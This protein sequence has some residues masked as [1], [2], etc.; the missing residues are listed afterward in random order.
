VKV[1]ITNS[2][3][4]VFT[5]TLQGDDLMVWAT[6]LLRLRSFYEE[7]GI[8][9]NLQDWAHKAGNFIADEWREASASEHA[10]KL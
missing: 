6:A 2:K 1:T 4:E 7:A 5:K 8:G 10:E 3:G 9:S